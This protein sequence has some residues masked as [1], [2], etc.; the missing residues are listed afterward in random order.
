MQ[1]EPLEATFPNP[2]SAVDEAQFEDRHR[3]SIGDD[4]G[5]SDLRLGQFHPR[6]SVGP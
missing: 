2:W 3:G 1:S 4:L 5:A 6:P